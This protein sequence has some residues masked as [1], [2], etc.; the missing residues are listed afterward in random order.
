ME[1]RAIRRL[2]IVQAMSVHSPPTQ[3]D[4]LDHEPCPG[5]KASQWPRLNNILLAPVG[6]WVGG[7]T[8]GGRSNKHCVF[9]RTSL[10]IPS[11]KISVAARL[12]LSG[13]L[14]I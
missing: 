5:D 2:L 11:R 14:A 1:E 3:D 6:G 13:R 10:H 4:K 12:Y 8:E 9:R 7:W